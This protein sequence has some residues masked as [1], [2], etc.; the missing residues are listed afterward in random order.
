MA[1]TLLAGSKHPPERLQSRRRKLPIT[2]GVVQRALW[3]ADA[4]T[5][6]PGTVG[7]DLIQVRERCEDPPRTDMAEPERADAWRIDHPTAVVRQ[8]QSDR[9]CRRVAAAAGD[10]ANRSDRPFGSWNQGVDQGG[11]AYP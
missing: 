7:T 1:P 10:L 3:L 8:S 4:V 6:A 11:L 9:G 5:A 2:D